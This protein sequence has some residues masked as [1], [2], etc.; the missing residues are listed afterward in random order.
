MTPEPVPRRWP[1]FLIAALATL[2]FLDKAF[3]IDDVLYLRVADQILHTPLDPYAGIVLWD[4]PDGQPQSLFLTDFNPPLWKYQLAAVVAVGGLDEWRLHL[5]Q[6]VYT[7]LAGLALF[8]IARRWTRH[9]AWC[10]AVVLLG[11]FFLPGQNVMLE[12]SLLA[13]SL[14]GLELSLRAWDDGRRRWVLAAGFCLG[15][16]VLT[17]YTAGALLPVVLAESLRRRRPRGLWI[18]VIAAAA[19][20]AWVG[21][22]ELVYGQSHFGAQGLLQADAG[23]GSGASELRHRLRTTLRTLGGVCV[24]T[25]ALLYL[26]AIRVRH[27]FATALALA[28]TAGLVAWWDLRTVRA[29]ADAEG[30]RPTALQAGHLLAFT[31]N[32]AAAALATAVL[33]VAGLADRRVWRDG[34]SPLPLLGLLL[35]GYFV[36]NVLFVPFQAVRHLLFYLVAQTLLV[37]ALWPTTAWARRLRTATLLAA[38]GLGTALAVSDYVIAG[39]YRDLARTEVRSQVA[40]THGTVW[41]TGAWGFWHYAFQNGAYPLVERPTDYAMPP[42]RSGDMIVD[43]YAISFWQPVK[44]PPT[45]S[46]LEQPAT[47]LPLRTVSP[48]ANWY[49]VG[50]NSLPWEILLWWDADAR[51]WILPPAEDVLIHRVR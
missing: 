16:A 29:I 35:G 2:P 46:T 13:F 11:P 7:L 9:P 39:F 12:P 3:H 43:P 17:K 44:R 22:N 1:V 14:W 34:R 45:S 15:A 32:G 25:P 47:W 30:W 40:R 26:V 21:H 4:A 50:F 48:T 51:W 10:V 42:L 24:Y 27:G 38:V 6:G 31:A 37:G 5:W 8:E 19:L 41:F 36:F 18:V 33:V 23:D 28:I 49:A 20:L